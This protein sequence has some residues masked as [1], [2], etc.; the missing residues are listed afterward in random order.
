M[1]ASFWLA[2]PEKARADGALLRLLSGDVDGLDVHELVDA[3]LGKF[4]AEA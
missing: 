4:A 3:M 1:G 2:L